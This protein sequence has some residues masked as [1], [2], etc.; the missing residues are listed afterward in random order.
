MTSRPLCTAC[1]RRCRSAPGCSRAFP[2]LAC[3]FLP[4][5][6]A[7]YVAPGRISF[8][9]SMSSRNARQGASAPWRSTASAWPSRHPR[10]SAVDRRLQRRR[11]GA[12]LAKAKPFQPTAVACSRAAW[13]WAHGVSS[14]VRAR[15]WRLS[16]RGARTDATG[17]RSWSTSLPGLI[18]AAAPHPPGGSAKNCVNGCRDAQGSRLPCK[19]CLPL[20]VTRHARGSMPSGYRPPPRRSRGASVVTARGTRACPAFARRS[21]SRGALLWP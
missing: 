19:Q 15:S 3:P 21:A 10:Y 14:P 2:P 7:A 5:P 13:C 17:V 8:V 11:R 6:L 20:P 1:R 4:R 9:R 18:G 12:W 16:R